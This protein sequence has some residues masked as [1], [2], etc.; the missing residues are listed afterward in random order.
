MNNNNSKKIIFI[1]GANGFIG[2]N[3]TRALVDGNNEIHVLVKSNN[4]IW[5]LKDLKD[6]IIFHEFDIC[7]YAKLAFTIKEIKPTNVFNLIHYGGNAGQNDENKIRQVI[8]EGTASLFNA[9][10]GID[11]IKSIVNTGSSS[12][13][14][15]KNIP[16]SEDLL[17]EPN[18]EYSVAKVWATLYGQHC[19]REKKIPIVTARLF[20]VYG[21]FEH[22]NRFVTEVILA[23]LKGEKPKLASPDTVRDFI[24]V[25]DV[26]N[27]LITISESG[28]LGD[29]YNVG[30]GKE[31]T[32]QKVAELVA[33]NSNYSHIFEWGNYTARSFD[34]NKWQANIL[35]TEEKIGW[36]YQIDIED[37]IKKTVDWFRKNINLYENI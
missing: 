34:T 22:R 25:D 13:Y 18:T 1:T 35:Y 3:L 36:K 24:Y 33:K 29:V 15:K 7:N 10:H 31:S 14:G 19:F 28:R 8:I 20:S 6:K 21:P 27:A 9:C 5:R 26:V 11:S 37:G 17:P 23:C 12:E 30:T 32:L 4:N 16:M 2:S